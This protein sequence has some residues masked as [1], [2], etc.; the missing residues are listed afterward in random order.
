MEEVTIN[1][2]VLP[3]LPQQ[4]ISYEAILNNEKHY[5]AISAHRRFGT[6]HGE[7]LVKMFVDCL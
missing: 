7:M 1:L 4:Q 2:P 6:P 5:S 3:L